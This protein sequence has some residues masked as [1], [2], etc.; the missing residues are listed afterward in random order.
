M[1]ATLST[2]PE[3]AAGSAS[4]QQ[5][6]QTSAS[7]QELLY[8]LLRAL[9]KICRDHPNESR[10]ELRAPLKWA[11]SLKPASFKDTAI[12][13]IGGSARAGKPVV[14]SIATKTDGSPAFLLDPVSQNG[15]VA[16]LPE[17]TFTARVWTLDHLNKVLEVAGA[18]KLKEIQEIV[19][20][21]REPM[22][23]MFDVQSTGDSALLEAFDVINAEA[24][25][26]RKESAQKLYKL[27]LLVHAMDVQLMQTALL[28]MEKERVLD[29]RKVTEELAMLQAFCGKDQK[30]ALASIDWSS[31]YTFANGYR[32][33]P[34]RQVHN[35]LGYMEAVPADSE[36]VCITATKGGYFVNKGYHPDDKGV[37]HL[38]YTTSSE[39][40]PTLTALLRS[41]SKHFAARVESQDYLYRP[42]SRRAL[43]G[44]SPGPGEAAEDDE[45]EQRNAERSARRTDASARRTANNGANNNN[46]SNSSQAKRRTS[47]LRGGA[48]ARA[49]EPS[50]KWR[51]LT[52]TM[53]DSAIGRKRKD[54]EKGHH[55]QRA[56]SESPSKSRSARKNKP[57]HAMSYDDD[58]AESDESAV[59]SEEETTEKR[60]ENSELP[61]EYF[62]IQKLVKYLRVGNQTATII[63]ICSLRDFDLSNGKYTI[64]SMSLF[65]QSANHNSVY[66]EFNQLAIRD[67]GG[68]DTLVNLLDTDDARCKIVQI[69]NAI[70]D[71]DGMLSL[72]ELLVDPD[73]EI[74]CLAAETIAHCARNA[75]NRRAVRRYGG[76]R[77]L[78][79]LL[80]A[81]PGSSDE[82]VAISGALALE[83]CSK[84]ANNKD[85][86][87][88]AGAIPLLAALLESKN[89]ELLIPVVGI[90][91]ECASDERYRLAIRKT[92]MIKF[93]VEHLSSKNVN[94]LC[95]CASAIFK[96]ACEDETRELV[97]QYNGLTP[98]VNLLDNGGNK[99]LLVAATGAV[100]KCAQNLTN[101]AAFNKLNTI[102]K[103]VGLMDNQPEDVL[104]NVVGALG[105][106]AQ[107]EEGRRVLRESGG[108][109]PLVNLLTGTNQALLVNVTTAVG[110]CALDAESMNVIDR[111]D[112]VR[113]LWS[114]L[115]SPSRQVQASAA[116]AISP[117]I[118]HAKDAGEMVRSFVGG[119]ELIVSLLKSDDPDV[120][121]S[122]CAAIA[123]IACDE[124]NL[125]VI[126]DHGVV[127]MLAKL[128]NTRNDKLR[129]HLS[130]AIARCCR[131]GNNRV[132]FGAAG[133]VAPLVKYLK[134]PDDEVHR[135]T[136][137]A[138]HQ[139]SMDPDNCITMHEQGVVQL[140]LS[141]VGSPDATLQEAAAGTIGN[142][143]R[144]A[145][146]SEKA[147]LS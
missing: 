142:I 56:R 31:D 78:V 143:R 63:A 42:E 125:A 52:S 57:H 126:T 138:L 26:K 104:V 77:K 38:D 120:L 62:Q 123:N 118:E 40:F 124:E 67:V 103:L 121:A 114:L 73:E 145:L 34:W 33:P 136:A 35:E 44:T 79:R 144:L 21:N 141:M 7:N 28:T 18:G 81:R 147:P 82:K 61:A 4:A 89:E 48:P 20:C 10:A 29:V 88:A 116:W 68:L 91:Q 93:L 64:L 99:D 127:P 112:G 131:W 25:P 8:D 3:W 128:A 19:E 49:A 109:T 86:I 110:A 55:A 107:T 71:L 101:V 5:Q 84:S 60:Q 23:L 111:L 108:I 100:W 45:V 113:L 14:T 43:D 39:T 11:T 87:Q 41:I 95:H 135:T 37:P 36:K 22:N 132:A 134:S 65:G 17:P 140:L 98:L 16:T 139:L 119:L 69:R 13:N 80:K 1:G 2:R 130:E 9:Q 105:A 6:L 122:V 90:L 106:C 92:G 129:K 32:A 54:A 58:F 30:Y 75:R 133:A 46:N 51:A 59:T 27:L 83:S 85:A 24:D 76:V 96:C 72:V 115:K 50:M 15:S 102:K 47:K 74:K 94:L 66:A 146:V 117:C 53:D 137:R 97:R 70:A 12:W